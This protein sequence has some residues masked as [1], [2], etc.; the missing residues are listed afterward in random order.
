MFNNIPQKEILEF[1]RVLGL[2]LSAKLSFIASLELMAPKI[3]NV[4]LK[5]VL[6]DIN[7]NIKNGQ[8]ISKSFAK[9]KELFSDSYIANLKIGEE[10]GDVGT[11]LNEYNKFNEKIASLKKKILQAVRYPLMV[12]ITALGA[13]IFMIFFLIPSF[14]NIFHN[15]NDNLPFITKWIIL[16]SSF[17][18][19]NYLYLLT[20][21]LV[22]LM[23]IKFSWSSNKEFYFKLLLR[24][25][26]VANLYRTNILARFTQSMATLLKNRLPLIDSLTISKSITS[27]SLFR[28]EI[29]IIIKRINKGESFSKNIKSEFLDFTFYKLLSVGE[30]SAELD[31]SFALLSDYYTKEFDYRIENINSL[32]EPVLIIFVGSIVGVILVSLYMPMFDII[33]NVGF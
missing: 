7:K 10:T 27:N 9:H 11:L 1:N 16:F 12:L 20:I 17:I 13:I 22:A 18:I 21:I 8:S 28:K 25:P 4:K 23:A 29:D 6:L 30:A 19:N 14:E 24:L 5:N 2:L 33:N 31:N 15:S 32:I 26:L 3:E